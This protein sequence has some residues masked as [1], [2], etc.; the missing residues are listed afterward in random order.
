MNLLSDEL[1]NQVKEVFSGLENQVAILYF[2]TEGDCETCEETRQLLDDVCELSDK[3]SLT[4]Y[5]IEK[6]AD[7]ARQYHVDKVPGIVIA[8]KD[9]DQVTDYGIRFAG[10]PSGIEFTSLVNDLV[11]V[12]SRNSDLGEATRSFLGSLTQPVLLQVF[13]TPT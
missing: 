1:A 8:A 6:D 5:D 10:I 7:I 2:S 11:L 13:T 4:V 9:G 12:S 3:F